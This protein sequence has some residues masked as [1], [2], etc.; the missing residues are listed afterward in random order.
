MSATAMPTRGISFTRHRAIRAVSGVASAG[1]MA[2]VSLA[3]ATSANAAT[4]ADCTVANT[5]DSTAVV[6]GTAADIQTLMDANTPVICLSG[7]FALAASLTY[8]YD[9]TIHGVIDAVLDGGNSVGILVDSGANTITVESLRFTRGNDTSAAAGNKSGAIRGS[10]GA[11]SSTIIVHNSQFDNNSG[12]LGGA[13]SAHIVEIY[14]SQFASNFAD[15]TGG[16]VTAWTSVTATRSTFRENVSQG[17][18]AIS[19]YDVAT[20]DSSTF[21]SNEAL[22]YG[23]AIDAFGNAEVENS[24]FVG[25]T[26]VHA[27]AARGGAIHSEGGTVRQSTFLDNSVVTSRGESIAVEDGTMELRGNIFAGSGAEPHLAV[28]AGS[29]VDTGANLFTTTQAVEVALTS[30]Q[31]STQFEL[32]TLAI[33]NGATLADNGGPTQTIA[34]HSGSPAIRAV[35]ADASSM[36]VDQRGTARPAVSDAGAFEFDNGD[37]DGSGSAGSGDGAEL[38]AT[39]TETAGWLTGVAALLFAAGLAVVGFARRRLRSI[40]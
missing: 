16:A 2:G 21:E 12:S 5:V 4:D 6:P 14:D 29:F 17:G 30:V 31:P 32:T 24:T 13:I 34:L 3:G 9:L 25:N 36:T 1:L 26:A 38:A 10:S 37:A 20:V 8:N 19:S 27:T 39:G 15:S 7:T 40:R 23:G 35:S 11:S 18:G 28:D 33:F 22:Y